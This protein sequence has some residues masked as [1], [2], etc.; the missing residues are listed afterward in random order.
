MNKLCA[1]LLVL[2]LSS[3]KLFSQFVGE[4]NR[5]LNEFIVMLKPGHSAEQLLQQI[6]SAKT[7]ECLS[8]R[9]NIYLLER[10]TISSAEGF[11]LS[12]QRNENI[13]LAQFNHRG[14]EQRSLM[15][16][17]SFFD[18]QW[19]MLNTG[20]SGGIAGADID[21]TEAWEINNDNITADGDTVVVAIVDGTFDMHHEE[22]NYFV[23]YN[24]IDSNGID[25]DGNTYIDDRSGWNV[26]TNSGNVHG[27][28]DPH[29]THLSGIVGA[30]GNNAK[31]VA[32]VCWGVKILPINRKSNIE[33]DVV[34]AYD[35][36]YT[37]RLLYNNTFGTKGAF[38]VATNSS[39]GVNNGNP[40]DYQV[41]C[42][43]Y[44]ALGA[45]GILNVAATANLNINVDTQHDMPTECPSKWMIAVT[46]TT[47]TD[48]R[49]TG[50]AYGQINIDLGA[51]GT[52]VYSTVPLDSYG[53][54]T[55]TSMSAPH[56]AG[57]VAA[58]YSAACTG[59]I[60]AY[61]EYP[62]SISLTIRD[63]LLDGT[64]WNSSLNNIAST[65]GSLNLLRA[66]LNL[67]K[68]NC[69][70]CGFNIDI[71]K[72]P[73]SCK[74]IGDGAIAVT[75]D[76]GSIFDYD[77]LWSNGVAAPECL[78]MEPG[79]YTVSV[80]D[81]FTG[82]RRYTTAELHNPDTILISAINIV[83]AEGGSPGNITVVATAGN[84]AL[85][86]SLD[87]ISYQQT[88]TFSVPTN[89]TYTIYI[90]NNSGC[91]V[92]QNVIVSGIDELAVDRWQLILY[93]NPANDELAVYSLQFPK[94]R[95]PLQ[96]FDLRGR[97][98]YEVIPAA[99]NLQLT[100]ANFESG[101]YFLRFGNSATKFAVIH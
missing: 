24:E 28:I 46:N 36:V 27:T 35:Y 61:H 83:P 94:A 93:P 72:I 60:D 22:I 38:I 33:S 44:D 100:T 6:P 79:F 19:N 81:T 40:V 73:I 84:D 82:C 17:D 7:K 96:V 56:V 59:L 9:M 42:A 63:Y 1:I 30:I 12:L 29:S 25:D 18:L 48:Q 92:Q 75:T 65:N 55:G 90:K 20:Q 87:G 54:N 89:G 31:G 37:M 32:G 71:D 5:I 15:P 41:W 97:K 62:D 3:A 49:N 4:D 70:S 52:G 14:I 99:Y 53:Y 77:I 13:K 51:P 2:M 86:Y 95:Y 76:S 47:R 57:T 80:R 34:M 21:A 98:I 39:F 50:A 91:V 85:V 45:L 67:K 78:S 23:N 26:A 11:L 43:M 68:Y 66:I 16:N 64:E 69:D 101:V 10:N 88:A 74:S 58:M 8:K